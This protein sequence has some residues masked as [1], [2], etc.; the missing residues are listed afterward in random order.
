MFWLMLAGNVL[1]QSALFQDGP[2]DPEDYVHTPAMR[3]LEEN[4]ALFANGWNSSIRLPDLDETESVIPRTLNAVREAHQ[5]GTIDQDACNK[6]ANTWVLSGNHVDLL[7][8][9]LDRSQRFSSSPRFSREFPTSLIGEVVHEDAPPALRFAARLYAASVLNWVTLESLRGHFDLICDRNSPGNHST[10]L[11]LGLTSNSWRMRVAEEAMMVIWADNIPIAADLDDETASRLNSAEWIRFDDTIEPISSEVHQHQMAPQHAAL[12]NLFLE[13]V[14]EFHPCSD[15]ELCGFEAGQEAQRDILRALILSN[16]TSSPWDYS[17]YYPLLVEIARAQAEPIHVVRVG[18]YP[19]QITLTR[20]ELHFA[21]SEEA[22]PVEGLKGILLDNVRDI[23]VDAYQLNLEYLRI[24]RSG[25]QR[26]YLR[27]AEL[28]NYLRIEHATMQ[29]SSCL[30]LEGAQIRHTDIEDFLD[31]GTTATINASQQISAIESPPSLHETALCLEAQALSGDWLDVRN[32]NARWVDARD[33]TLSQDLWLQNLQIYEAI[34]IDSGHFGAAW[35][36]DLG[37]IEPRANQVEVTNSAPRFRTAFDIYASDLS[38]DWEFHVHDS[39]GI[40]E[41]RLYQGTFEVLRLERLNL[42]EN[43]SFWGADAEAIFVF[44]VN[45]LR[46]IGGDYVE[47]E[48]VRFRSENGASARGIDLDYAD[49]KRRLEIENY[50]TDWL[51]LY[52]ARLGNVIISCYRAFDRIRLTDAE[53]EGI[54][55]FSAVAAPRWQ[56]LGLRSPLLAF[57]SDE[58]GYETYRMSVTA[59]EPTEPPTS[60]DA[61]PQALVAEDAEVADLQE[62]GVAYANSVPSAPMTASP[63]LST[64]RFRFNS[65]QPLFSA[66]DM[67]ERIVAAA[68]SAFEQTKENPTR[69]MD[70]DERALGIDEFERVVRDGWEDSLFQVR[71]AERNDEVDENSHP[72][73]WQCPSATVFGGMQLSDASIGSLA[74][75]ASITTRLDMA[76]AD[77][78]RMVLFGDRMAFGFNAFW[79]LR[80]AR[81]DTLTIPDDLFYRE[82]NGQQIRHQPTWEIEGSEL[83]LIRLYDEER[84]HWDGFANEV[85][86]AEDETF[87]VPNARPRQAATGEDYKAF[88]TTQLARALDLGPGRSD[89]AIYRGADYE[90]LRRSMREAGYPALAST[91]AVWQ[92]NHYA[93]TLP[94][95]LPGRVT[96]IL[97]W[98]GRTINEYGYNTGLGVIHLAVLL[99][100]GT[101]LVCLRR[102]F[103]R[104]EDGKTPGRLL[105][106]RLYFFLNS[107]FISLGRTIPSVAVEEEEPRQ[108]ASGKQPSRRAQASVTRP[109]WVA[110]LLYLQRFLVFVVVLFM[111]GGVLNVFQ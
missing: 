102:P 79:N 51:A 105:E 23:S 66:H 38:V 65:E 10:T 97:F 19:G 14:A 77:I 63:W 36:S 81:V 80:S 67:Q 46:T 24:R 54:A 56:G 73:G 110:L 27:Q 103:P 91:V 85:E 50:D 111:I 40:G 64:P 86:L 47:A 78:D 16:W 57:S 28:S 34:R 44:D 88:L 3:W 76:R 8:M 45:A 106:E 52:G 20:D 13:D 74:I 30:N 37:F 71:E 60:L 1:A 41:I 69:W 25:L 101:I 6:L 29:G 58:A 39:S 68:L 18:F 49:I 15:V 5:S 104:A 89:A 98:L 9:F 31:R 92:N 108:P 93:E 55:Y 95:T 33:M 42:T 61:E 94:S 48:T 12:R 96:E 83:G 90:F 35:I 62:V 53:V 32:L 43:I 11:T 17:V 22:I 2:T 7:H 21:W 70:G 59:N 87:W 100:I 99:A 26:V 84:D 4:Q 107:L 82:T 109:D 75:G 72:T